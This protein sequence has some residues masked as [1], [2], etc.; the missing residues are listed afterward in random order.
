MSILVTRPSPFGERLV[1]Q[2]IKNG[3]EASHT[4]LIAFGP[5]DQLDKLPT[6]LNYIR[7]IDIVIV[8]SQHAVH[9]ASEKLEAENYSW[10]TNITYL[11]I[12]QKTASTLQNIIQ[13]PVDYPKGRETSEELLKLPQLQQIAGKKVL[14]LRGNGGREF[15]AEELRKSGAD[16]TFCE[17][18]KRHIINHDGIVICQLWQK[19]NI[20]KLVITSG[21]MLQQLY[22]LV[23]VIYRLWL[24][25]CQIIVVSERLAAKA[26]SLGWQR[27]LIADNADNDALFRA[28]Q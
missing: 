7:S 12:G 10:P 11:A 25:S 8:A 9:Y 13:I 1:E 17:C 27:C 14:I 3:M 21:E 15:L 28:L 18:Y 5:G 19:L 23:P 16:V 2:L 26:R 6:H 20:D 4:P 22:D 24:L